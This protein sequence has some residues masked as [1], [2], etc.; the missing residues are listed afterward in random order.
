MIDNNP[1]YYIVPN[2]MEVAQIK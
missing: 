2:I 1:L